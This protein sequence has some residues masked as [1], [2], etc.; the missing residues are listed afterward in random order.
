MREVS[1]KAVMRTVRTHLLGSEYPPS[2]PSIPSASNTS[3]RYCPQARHSPARTSMAP[4]HSF[5]QRLKLTGYRPAL[6]AFFSPPYP[7]S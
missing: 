2:F 3:G 6:P 5:P 4:I 1:A 7:R